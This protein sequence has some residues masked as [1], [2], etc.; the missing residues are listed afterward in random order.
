MISRQDA[1]AD[2]DCIRGSICYCIVISIANV[3]W[4]RRFRDGR[5]RPWSRVESQLVRYCF[6]NF[7]PRAGPGPQPKTYHKF[8][9]ILTPM[10]PENR[11]AVGDSIG[12]YHLKCA[13]EH[14]LD[15]VFLVDSNAHVKD[16]LF[17][18]SIAWSQIPLPMLD[19]TRPKKPFQFLGDCLDGIADRSSLFRF[20]HIK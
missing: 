19:K 16:G 15:S 18:S 9:C 13:L 8:Q 3:T 14:H 5:G 2:C 11:S 10:C 1:E 4:I 12:C 17:P 7:E 6:Y 20:E